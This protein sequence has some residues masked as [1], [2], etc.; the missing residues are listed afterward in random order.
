M[1]WRASDLPAR[2][3]AAGRFTTW[4]VAVF[5]F[6][7]G[8]AFTGA[9]YVEALIDQWTASVSG[10]LTVQIPAESGGRGGGAARAERAVEALTAL[11]EVARAEI[12]ARAQVDAL[13]KPWLVDERLIADL[14]LPI[15]VDVSLT[16]A[17]PEAVSAV[18][19]ALARAVPE[20]AVDDHRAWLGRVV[21]LAGGFRWLAAAM[22][23]MVTAALAL[24]VVFATK[25]S[26][27]EAAPV[28]EA[29]HLVGAKDGYVAGQFSRR[30]AAQTLTGGAIGAAAFAP[31]LIAIGWLAGRID[32]GVLPDVRLPWIFWAG[33]AGL[34]L[35]A[36]ALAALTAN[37]TVRRLLAR[38][39]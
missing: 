1:I 5:V 34:P 19:A 11:P 32:A 3:D 9:V 6:L 31:A 26:L 35:V 14:P 28:V 16:T 22:F 2:S 24:T 20:A 13:L 21:A 33:L 39:I 23:A 17:T 29:L 30:A 37:L 18:S 10:T 38:M 36:T 8:V 12:V 15:L 7:A 4:L 27:V 25:A